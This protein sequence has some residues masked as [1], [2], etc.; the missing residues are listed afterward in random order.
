MAGGRLYCNA[1]RWEAVS[2]EDIA[3]SL[4]KQCRYLGHCQGFYS[5]AEHSVLV[6]S[7]LETFWLDYAGPL[8]LE[9]A[10]FGVLPASAWARMGLLG[11]LHDA[12]EAY[13]GDTVRPWKAADA[14][15]RAFLSDRCR[16]LDD[17][18]YAALGVR[19]P[20]LPESRLVKLADDVVTCLESQVLDAHAGA[21]WPF[22]SAVRS[23]A[24]RTLEA[25]AFPIERLEWSEA[26]SAFIQRYHALV[27]A[28]AGG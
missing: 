9:A 12:H 6:S 13:V 16:S 15:L 17:A 28:R 26:C 24:G 3:A 18:I 7:W 2:L 27:P 11:L 23:A 10:E 21:G 5:V 22:S 19:P 8:A 20:T 14:Q 25:G 1:P 4:S